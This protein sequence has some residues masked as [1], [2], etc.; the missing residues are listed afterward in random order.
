MLPASL[1]LSHHPTMRLPT[2]N[3]NPIISHPIPINHHTQLYPDP[4]TILIA[5]PAC[6]SVSLLILTP[7]LHPPPSDDHPLQHHPNTHSPSSH[8][9]YQFSCSNNISLPS[10][11][12]FF[13]SSL[14]LT[15]YSLK[16]R[17]T[18]SFLSSL[19]NKPWNAHTTS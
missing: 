14:V 6:S 1:S 3:M 16:W 17:I 10:S 5:T 2:T 8:Q 7:L 9:L 4:S 13:F 12:F 19:H 15:R 11:F 18:T